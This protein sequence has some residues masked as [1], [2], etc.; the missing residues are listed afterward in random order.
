MITVAQDLTSSASQQYLKY[1]VDKA[2]VSPAFQ[3]HIVSWYHQLCAY[4]VEQNHSRPGEILNPDD[5]MGLLQEFFN[6]SLG[7]T[8]RHDVVIKY[9]GGNAV[10]EAARIVAWQ[11]PAATTDLLLQRM[12]SAQE[13]TAS[14]P[15]GM[16]AHSYSFIFRF[17]HQVR[18]VRNSGYQVVVLSLVVVM[19]ITWFFFE[20][21][22]IGALV[23]T[24]LIAVVNLNL[25]GF[26]C[27]LSVEYNHASH[28]VLVIGIGFSVDYV[29]HLVLAFARAKGEYLK[30]TSCVFL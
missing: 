23:C 10:L 9:V 11:H 13:L 27:L 3:P 2:H 29:A 25:F 20:G 15:P 21:S 12:A 4:A 26:M 1:L 18:D 8:F 28:T 30:F 5:V 14:P 7:A 24:A 17:L 19:F 6:T 22:V 16:S